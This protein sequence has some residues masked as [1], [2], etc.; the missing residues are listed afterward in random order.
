MN[1]Y[2]SEKIAGLLAS[3]GYRITGRPSEADLVVVNTCAIRE[4]AEQKVFSYL[5]RLAGLKRRRTDMLVA[6]GGCVA[7]QQGD[8]IPARQPCVDI[9]F[10]TQAIGRLPALVERA[11]AG[12]GP[13]IDTGPSE[14]IEMISGA[15]AGGLDAG[16]SRFVTIMRGC[17]NYCSYCV[18]PFVRGREVSR[19]P[20]AVVAEVRELVADGA[21]EVTLLGQ[22]VNSYGRKEGLCSFARLLARVNAVDGL[23]RIRFTTSHPKDLSDELIAAFGSLDKLCR[24]LH[25]PV[26]SGSDA[27]LKRMNRGYTRQHY[28]ARVERVRAASPGIALSTD[29]IVGFPGETEEDFRQ[30]LELIREVEYDS[31]FAFKYSDRPDA[32][33]RRFGRKVAEE[34]KKRRLKAVLDTQEHITRRKNRQC[35]GRIETVLV[36]GVS[37]RNAATG[38][39]DARMQWTGRTSENRIVNFSREEGAAVAPPEPGQLVDVL[40]EKA[41][42]HSLWGRAPADRP[43]KPRPKGDA[44]YAA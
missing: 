43:V 33:A 13:L 9:V 37:R 35:V 30:T 42:A 18:V 44:C 29:I 7:Q 39:G 41:F 10:G 38:T 6:V 40:I 23:A 12:F 32:P 25:L 20:E 4:K 31:L 5:G 1:V 3:R 14:G 27:V 34:E 2:D 16:I 19:N 22:N 28:L 24:H 17:D 26:Q 8:R 15:P 36:E 11:E 21:R